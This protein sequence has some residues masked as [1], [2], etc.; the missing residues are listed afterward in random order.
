MHDETETDLFG[1][2]AVLCGGIVELMRCGFETLVEAGYEP[3]N[4]YFE[5]IHEMKLIVDLINKGG[6]A[7]MNYSIS[8]T[9]E[10]GEYVSGPRILPYEQTKA[11][12]KAVLND[13]Q[14]GTFAGKWIAENCWNYGFIIR[15]QK[16]KEDITEIIYEPWHLRYVGVQIAQYMHENNLCLEEFTNEWKEAAAAYQAAEN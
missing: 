16:D 11:N 9:A 12:M 6:V 3:E 2:Q 13:I 8:D 1:E 5:C 7:A 10:Y 4:A 15:Y 14:D